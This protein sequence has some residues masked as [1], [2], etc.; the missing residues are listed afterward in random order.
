M[1]KIFFVLMVLVGLVAFAQTTTT[2]NQ[3]AHGNQGPWKVTCTNCSGGGSSDAGTTV[4]ITFD[5]GFIGQVTPIYC[6]TS[7]VNS[8]TSVGTSS[9]ATP[10]ATA[11][12]RVSIL[13]CNSL[14]NTGTPLVKCRDDNTAVALGVGNPGEAINPGDCILYNSKVGVRCIANTAATAV[15]TFECVP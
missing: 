9:T 13:V 4:N 1:K 6:S 15:S 11:S 3:G 7:S 10:A 2:V 12:A 8:V 14:E 5:G